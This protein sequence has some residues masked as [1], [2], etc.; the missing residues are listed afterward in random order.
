MLTTDQKGA[1]AEAAI[2]A[3]AVKLGIDVYRSMFDHGGRYD[4]IFEV[5]DRL[6]RVQCKWAPLHG[7]VVVV[8]RC[9][10]TRRAREGLR[11]RTY[12]SRDTDLIVAYCQDLDRC[13][14][15]EPDRFAEH[16]ERRLRVRPCRNN[17]RH[18]VLWADDFAFEALRFV[19]GSG[20]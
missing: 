13:F 11:K 12:S 15:L 19:D 7:D 20:P 8:V 14:V 1:I 16:F 10:S 3:A 18:G 6:V 5:G 9:Y 2:A 4:L 17:Q